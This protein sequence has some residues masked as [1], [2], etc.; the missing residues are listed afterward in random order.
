VTAH[1]AITLHA[2]RSASYFKTP[3][4]DVH[5]D[6]AEIAAGTAVAL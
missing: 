3:R 2:S 1:H 5:A 4:L 6:H